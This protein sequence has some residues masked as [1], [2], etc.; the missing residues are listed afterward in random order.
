MHERY[1]PEAVAELDGLRAAPRKL[2]RPAASVKGRAA[3]QRFPACRA[4]P[5]IN[6]SLLRRFKPMTPG[7]LHPRGAAPQR[8][9]IRAPAGLDRAGESG[10]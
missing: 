10:G 1:G 4:A 8:R 3:Q 7:R 2:Q 6:H 5:A 9:G